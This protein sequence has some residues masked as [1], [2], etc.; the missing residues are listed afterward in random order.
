MLQFVIIANDGDDE[1]AVERRMAVRP[2]HLE[3]VRKLKAANHYVLGGAVLNEEGI[4]KG[5]VMI[6]QF[7][8]EAEM[9]NWFDLEP[10][11]LGHVWQKIEIRPFKVADV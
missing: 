1:K 10:Y 4:M 7:E 2:S 11:V 8:T 6:V 5:S 9:R 3:G